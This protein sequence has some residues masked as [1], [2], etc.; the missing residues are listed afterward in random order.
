VEGLLKDLIT[1][2]GVIISGVHP[3]VLTGQVTSRT[4]VGAVN[5]FLRQ[6]VLCDKVHTFLHTYVHILSLCH[7]YPLPVT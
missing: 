6:H 3:E 2:G 4:D 5:D 1:F 7:L